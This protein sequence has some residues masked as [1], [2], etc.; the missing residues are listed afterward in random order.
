MLYL[1]SVV[2]QDY[3]T[4]IHERIVVCSCSERCRCRS[5]SLSLSHVLG[6]VGV[7]FGPMFLSR[8][9]VVFGPIWDIWNS[10]IFGYSN[11]RNSR[12]KSGICCRVR[13]S[14]LHVDAVVSSVHVPTSLCC[15]GVQQHS[16]EVEHRSRKVE[17]SR[18]DKRIHVL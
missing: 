11:H 2:V 8:V 12:S 6:L 14:F 10:F 4:F 17:R 3:K 1:P 5:L 18:A 16:K 9:G 13:T 7:A 15:C